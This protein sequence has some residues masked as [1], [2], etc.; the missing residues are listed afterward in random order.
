MKISQLHN[1]TKVTAQTIIGEALCS[2]PCLVHWAGWTVRPANAGT[3]LWGFSA[4]QCVFPLDW[5][6]P[7]IP[8]Q[9]YDLSKVFIKTTNSGDGVIVC[10]AA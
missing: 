2:S 5:M 9:R 3:V 6:L 10:A 8:G 7:V 4:D 1:I